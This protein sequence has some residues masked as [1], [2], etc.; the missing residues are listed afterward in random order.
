[1][2]T[3]SCH[4]TNKHKF[5]INSFDFHNTPE[6]LQDRRRMLQGLWPERGCEYCRNIEDAGGQSDRITNLDF[7]GIHAPPELE[8]EPGAI[9]VTPRIL[10]VYFD[11]TC[12]LKCVYCGPHFSS[13]WDA[14]NR[15]HGAFERNGLK[16]N[17]GF[18]KHPDIDQVKIKIFD[19][20]REHGHHLTNFNILGGEPLFQREFDQCLDLF[21]QH[22]APE[23]DLQIFT[24]LNTKFQ[25]LQTVV[26]RVRSLV[27]RKHLKE[28]TVTASLDCW[29]PQQEYIR[30]PL[31]LTSWQKNFEY[32]VEQSWIKLIVGSTLTPLALHT[33]PDLIKYI[34][35]H[36]AQRPIYQYFNSVNSPSYM[37]I[38]IL[39]GIFLDDFQRAID[40][41]PIDEPEQR[42]V[43]EYLKGIAKQSAHRGVNRAEVIK[44]HTFLEEM[45]RRRNTNWRTTFPWLVQPILAQVDQ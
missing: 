23:L 27:D 41:L 31:D 21:D 37:Y 43:R 7:P 40:L 3:A 1:M 22:P 44:L 11:N 39:G 5:D 42:S 17:G 29:G 4:R 16:I 28:F 8:S 2:E 38:D 13:L 24:N 34:N 15:R 36:R 19:W 12:N 25:H 32:L 45:D 33:F 9:S 18:N 14:E 6:K 30:F 10:E 35:H 20:L 26:Q